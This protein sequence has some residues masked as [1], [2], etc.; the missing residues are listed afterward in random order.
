MLSEVFYVAV[1]RK[2]G[3]SDDNDGKKK[4]KKPAQPSDWRTSNLNINEA[5][6]WEVVARVRHGSQGGVAN[7]LPLALCTFAPYNSPHLPCLTHLRLLVGLWHGSV[8]PGF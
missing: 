4:K 6:P 5:V 2:P 3:G 7:C 1:W 8:L